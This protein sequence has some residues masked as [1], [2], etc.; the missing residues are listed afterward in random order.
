[1]IEGNVLNRKEIVLGDAPTEKKNSLVGDNK[2]K[3]VNGNASDTD[4]TSIGK[5]KKNMLLLL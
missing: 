4:W 3:N 5:R 1:M 2:K